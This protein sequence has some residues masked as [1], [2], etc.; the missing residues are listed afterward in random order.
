MVNKFL[1]YLFKDFISGPYSNLKNVFKTTSLYSL[2]M[3]F[4]VVNPF[5]T[6]ELTDIVV[7]FIPIFSPTII[8]FL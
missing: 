7:I 4:F 3:G 2:I 1:L 8:S 6:N 5:E